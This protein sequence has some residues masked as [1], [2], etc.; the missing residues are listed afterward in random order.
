MAIKFDA[1]KAGDTLYDVR[2][3]KAGNTTMS[4]INVWSVRVVSVDADNKTARVRWNGNPE[5]TYGRREIER[6]RRSP[7]KS[8]D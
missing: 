3:G 8:E 1:V 4:R 5:R 6:L 2:R 7:P